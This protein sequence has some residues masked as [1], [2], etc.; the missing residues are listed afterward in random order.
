MFIEAAAMS[1]PISIYN[2]YDP[3]GIYY[4]Q[5]RTWKCP[6]WMFIEAVAMSVLGSDASRI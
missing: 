2:E 1:V 6:T 5:L 4:D 3:I